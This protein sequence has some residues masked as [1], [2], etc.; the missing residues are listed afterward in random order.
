MGAGSQA[1]CG[2]VEGKLSSHTPAFPDNG[3]GMAKLCAGQMSRV[4]CRSL[5]MRHVWVRIL[6]VYGPYDSP[7]SLVAY[8]ISKLSAG[9]R[10]SFTA[11]EQLW[12]YVYSGDAA[13]AMTE[14][15]LKGK[16]GGIYCIGS[17][18][19]RRLSDFIKIIRDEIAPDAEL[20][21]GDVPYG[22]NQ[23]MYLCADISELQRD[24]GFTPSIEFEEGIKKT[25]EWYKNER[26]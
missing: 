26:K 16:D 13:K 22:A 19:T 4:A 23:V 2:I 15:A 5:G 24:T 21:L 14:L 8:A 9:E 11:G 7:R 6:S 3:Y 18:K 20:G 17:G 1:E 25:V 10:A 12:D